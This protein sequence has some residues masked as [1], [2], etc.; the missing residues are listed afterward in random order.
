MV[1]NLSGTRDWPGGRQFF[2]G[3]NWGCRGGWFGRHCEGQGATGPEELDFGM[4]EKMLTKA[5]VPHLVA[6]ASVGTSGPLRPLLNPLVFMWNTRQL[7]PL[8]ETYPLLPG[9]LQWPPKGFSD[10]S[11]SLLEPLLTE[12]TVIF[13]LRTIKSNQEIQARGLHN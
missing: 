10:S 2:Y 4:R 8:A 1:P 3:W 5:C 6:S 11:L 13:P 9:L 12:G 7:H